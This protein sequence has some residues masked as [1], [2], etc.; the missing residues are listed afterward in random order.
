MFCVSPGRLGSAPQP[1]GIGA[2]WYTREPLLGR[3]AQFSPQTLGIGR[4]LAHERTPLGRSAQ[5]YLLP[6]G[7]EA[8]RRSTVWNW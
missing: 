1:L 2:R 3:P 4:V 7:V 6:L 5:F 8:S